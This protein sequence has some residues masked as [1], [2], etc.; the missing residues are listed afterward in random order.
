MRIFF[1]HLLLRTAV[2]PSDCISGCQYI[3]A[4]WVENGG[5]SSCKIAMRSTSYLDK[6][7]FLFACV[8]TRYRIST[9][10]HRTSLLSL[11]VES[12]LLLCLWHPNIQVSNEGTQDCL[13]RIPSWHMTPRL[14]RW[15]RKVLT[16]SI[17]H[18]AL[19]MRMF[20]TF[21]LFIITDFRGLNSPLVRI[22]G[23]EQ[24]H[25]YENSANSGRT[26]HQMI[27]TFE[28]RHVKNG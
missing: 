12:T 25:R 9:C 7:S 10:A 6:V 28:V 16:I 3:W 22:L 27:R 14:S 11:G 5:S 18:S 2:L 15:T 13:V 8:Q 1:K 19:C 21:W 26:K 24:A 20:K 23:Y 17:L 4:G